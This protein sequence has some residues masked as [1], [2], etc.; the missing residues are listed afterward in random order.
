[1]KAFVYLL[2]AAVVIVGGWLAWEQRQEQMH[3]EVPGVPNNDTAEVFYQCD[4]NQSITAR[5]HA[6]D[7]EGAVAPEDKTA[8]QGLT[9]F[10]KVDLMLSDGRA[11]TLT[12]M[13]SEDGLRFSNRD[14]PN[15]GE[16]QLTFWTTGN[17]AFVVEDENNNEDLETYEGCIRVVPDPGGLLQIYANSERGFSIRYPT[18]YRLDEN[19]EYF[20][21]S[22]DEVIHGVRFV[23]PEDLVARTNLEDD[24]YVSVERL[25]GRSSCVADEFL[26][27]PTNPGPAIEGNIQYS[28]ATSAEQGDGN[29]YEE[30]V[31]A[32]PGTDP[33][34]GIRYFIHYKM[35]DDTPNTEVQ[36]FD[37]EKLTEQFDRIRRTLVLQ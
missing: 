33:C 23:I 29:Q 18:D 1:M 31:Y 22:P 30:T 35:I 34:T 9:S 2:I 25:P 12:R 36:E 37:K 24:T 21:L 14:A 16:E 13:M 26:S 7:T 5:Y 3:P 19:H 20:G 15:A 11:M 28:M 8:E 27:T 17:N 4:R 6:M 32:I 10:G